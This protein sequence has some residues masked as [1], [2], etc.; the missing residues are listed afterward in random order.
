M[1]GGGGCG[2]IIHI[3]SGKRAIM[4]LILPTYT[5]DILQDFFFVKTFSVHKDRYYFMSTFNTQI[6]IG[7]NSSPFWLNDEISEIL[8]YL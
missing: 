7:E 4:S 5:S 1:L 3:S 8:R 2:Q 6:Q